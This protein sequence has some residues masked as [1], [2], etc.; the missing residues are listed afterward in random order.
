MIKFTKKAK[1]FL[2]KRIVLSKVKQR[3]I[4]AT[5]DDVEEDDNSFEFYNENIENGSP[6][7]NGKD[8]LQLPEEEKMPRKESSALG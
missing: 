4:E 8:K 6:K 1:R 7:L 5:L 3:R 2:D